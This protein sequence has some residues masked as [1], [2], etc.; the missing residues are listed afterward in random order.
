MVIVMH[1]AG[2]DYGCDMVAVVET[3]MR[4]DPAAKQFEYHAQHLSLPTT[5]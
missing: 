1:D 3:I 4:E 2:V 5:L